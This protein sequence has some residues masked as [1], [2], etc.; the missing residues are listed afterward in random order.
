MKKKT[1][2][3]GVVIMYRFIVVIFF[4][5]VVFLLYVGHT[6]CEEIDPIKTIPIMKSLES[7]IS[8]MSWDF[9]SGDLEVDGQRGKLDNS[10]VLID[11]RTMQYLIARE[12]VAN[13]RKTVFSY[14]GQ[15]YMS[16]MGSLSGEVSKSHNYV[17]MGMTSNNA[18]DIPSS[19]ILE[20]NWSTV[21][22]FNGVP[23][24]FLPLFSKQDSPDFFSSFMNRWIKEKKIVSVVDNGNGAWNIIVRTE[25]FDIP[26]IMYISYNVTQRGIITYIKTSPIDSNIDVNTLSFGDGKVFFEL[27]VDTVQNHQGDWV[28]HKIT[29]VQPDSKIKSIM[30]YKNFSINPVARSDMF[31][32]VFPDGTYV[33]DKIRKMYYKVGDLI[34]EDKAISD[35]MTRHNLTGNVPHKPTYGNIVRIILI[36]IGGLMILASIILYINKKWLKS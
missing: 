4:L 21:G 25:I 27:S 20:K 1:Y 17:P 23:G 11:I 9:F 15:S 34:D 24:L 31:S 19:L 22:V 18:N 6:L 13:N 5:I 33:D 14:N 12:I 7:G 35:F 29:F 10:S 30:S 36:T 2:M 3:F 16:Y 28:P 8:T 32:L 26:Y